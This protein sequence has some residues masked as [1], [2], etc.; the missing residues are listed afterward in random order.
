MNGNGHGR[1]DATGERPYI[2]G[3]E[4]APTIFIDGM[5]GISVTNGVARVTLYQTV[6]DLRERDAEGNAPLKN[7]A[8]GRLAMS[9]QTF[10]L[11]SAWL[12]KQ[13]EFIKQIS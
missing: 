11:V 4:D 1:G 2:G 3:I 7:I 5:Q 9:V 10:E 13:N 12:S 8:V 6:Q